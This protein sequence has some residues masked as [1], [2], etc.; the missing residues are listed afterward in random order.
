MSV[1]W[2]GT[3]GKPAPALGGATLTR[4]TVGNRIRPLSTT[5]RKAASLGRWVHVGSEEL[6]LSQREL[7]E[8]VITSVCRRHQLSGPEADDFAGAV[9]LHLI[10]DDY[11][12]LRRF[13]NRSTLR[14][15]LVTVITHC[16][17]DYRNARWGKWRP[18]AEARRL[19]P[20]AVRLETLLVRD[21]LSLDEAHETLRTNFQATESRETLAQL[22]ARFPVRRGRTFV[23]VEVLAERPAIDAGAD[24]PAHRRDA[25]AAA[26]GAAATLARALAQLPALDR[27]ILKMRFNDDRSV[28]DISRALHLGQK[29]LYRHLDQLL[30]TL[31]RTL[32]AQGIK[33]AVIGD[34]L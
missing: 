32:E 9:R 27:L 1:Y 25:L 17:Q 21:G 14:T 15:Y 5:G 4:W 16:F 13:Q 20:L 6:Y 26:T 29:Q 11:A 31:R 23:S 30:A 7:I 24:A 18:S 3:M 19:G 22:A 33:A 34:L 8:H 2:N 28:A 12:I 10:E